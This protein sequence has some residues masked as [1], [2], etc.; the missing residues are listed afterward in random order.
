MTTTE[1]AEKAIALSGKVRDYWEV[2]LPKRHPRYPI[3]QAGED[4][5]PP[6]EE[7]EE[8]TR[9]LLDLPEETLYRLLL[10]MH[11]GRGDFG[12]D[13]LSGHLAQL[14]NRFDDPKRAVSQM[15]DKAPLPEFLCDG[16]AELRKHRIDI[17][18]LE[19]VA[20]RSR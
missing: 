3:V 16:L 20:G 13:D 6:P 10:V 1:A 8:L 19:P 7:E 11:L 12:I 2:E 14:R 18:D 9:F 15:T 17:D 5:G 4:S